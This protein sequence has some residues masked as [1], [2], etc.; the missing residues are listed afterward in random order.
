M[1]RTLRV[2]MSLLPIALISLSV[3]IL[4]SSPFCTAGKR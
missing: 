1:G 2:V 3:A 4:F